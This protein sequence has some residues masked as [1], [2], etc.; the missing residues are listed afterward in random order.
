MVTVPLVAVSVNETPQLAAGPG[1]SDRVHAPDEN[2]PVPAPPV[3][4]AAKTTWPDGFIPLTEASQVQE[5]GGTSIEPEGGGEG[6][7]TLQASDVVVATGEKV[8]E[9]LPVLGALSRSPG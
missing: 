5:G 4:V 3:L 8:R 9:T 7:E 2:V 6:G 1:P